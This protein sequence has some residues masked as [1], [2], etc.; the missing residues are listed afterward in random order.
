MQ[1][2]GGAPRAPQW[3]WTSS[4]QAHARIHRRQNTGMTLSC[5][6]CLR[7]PLGV[8][9][10]VALGSCSNQSEMQVLKPPSQRP[11]AL[12]FQVVL[13]PTW[14]WER[15]SPLQLTI[16]LVTIKVHQ[17]HPLQEGQQPHH[18]GLA[19]GLNH[20][21]QVEGFDSSQGLMILIYGRWSVSFGPSWKGNRNF[22]ST[23]TDS[24]IGY[25]FPLTLAALNIPVHS[26]PPGASTTA[27]SLVE[28]GR[29]K[30]VMEWS[31]TARR[32]ALGASGNSPQLPRDPAWSTPLFK[33]GEKCSLN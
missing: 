6:Y 7:G 10:S 25:Y 32:D 23:T 13:M 28:K 2:E 16:W 9:R 21:C 3:Q 33:L 8:S 1:G 18:S 20:P 22:I 19:Q 12:W 26:K 15:Q 24:N 31:P 14:A 29:H 11:S 4:R 30:G 5:S 27:S 17:I